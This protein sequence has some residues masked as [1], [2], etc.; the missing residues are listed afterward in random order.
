[1]DVD[2]PY[3]MKL[4]NFNVYEKGRGFDKYLKVIVLL[5]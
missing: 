2:N 1:M 5:D 3:F 4:H